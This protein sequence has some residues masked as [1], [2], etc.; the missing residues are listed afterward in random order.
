M[1]SD[2]RRTTNDERRTTNDE[3]R[4]GGSSVLVRNLH[5]PLRTIP[6]INDNVVTPEAL[7]VSTARTVSGSERQLVLKLFICGSSPRAESAVANLRR[8]CDNDLHGDY[9]LEVIDVLEQPDVAEEAKVLATPTLIKLLPPPLRR[10]IGDLSDK[11]KLLIGL[12]IGHTLNG[13]TPGASA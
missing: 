4:S 1:T 9:S 11:D 6:T 2:E 12:E 3:R 5:Y 8:I 7:D 13:P 10:I